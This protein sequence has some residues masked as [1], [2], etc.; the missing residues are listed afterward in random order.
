MAKSVERSDCSLLNL[1]LIKRNRLYNQY[2]I[3]AILS[4]RCELHL[5]GF[6]SHYYLFSNYFVRCDLQRSFGTRKEVLITLF[7]PTMM[8]AITDFG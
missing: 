2:L 3:R 4:P 7:R 8:S 6:F 1:D 5:G